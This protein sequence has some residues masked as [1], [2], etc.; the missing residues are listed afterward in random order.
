MVSERPT[1]ALCRLLLCTFIVTLEN[2]VALHKQ[3]AAAAA[4]MKMMMDRLYIYPVHDSHFSV[5]LNTFSGKKQKKKKASRKKRR[6]EISATRLDMS[7]VHHGNVA[8]KQRTEI[9]RRP[10]HRVAPHTVFARQAL[11]ALD[12]LLAFITFPGVAVPAHPVVRW[13][14]KCG[15]NILTTHTHT[16]GI[17]S[18]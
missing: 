14:L 9:R 18:D 4:M 16:Y 8:F 12:L 6:N 3:A 15:M 2:T 10:H 1:G 11:V 13:N 5:A 7:P 17:M